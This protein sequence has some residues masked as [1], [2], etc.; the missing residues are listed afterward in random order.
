MDKTHIEISALRYSENSK[1]EQ[2]TDVKYTIGGRSLC[3]RYQYHLSEA[4]VLA[5]I[6][7]TNRRVGFPAKGDA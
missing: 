4:M 7:M 2:H 1:G 6:E 5:Q 3:A